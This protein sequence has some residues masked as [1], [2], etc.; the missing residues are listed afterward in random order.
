MIFNVIFPET[1]IIC[2]NGLLN[3]QKLRQVYLTM[4]TISPRFVCKHNTMYMK[5]FLSLF[6]A[7]AIVSSVW[8]GGDLTS[9]QKVLS[10]SKEDLQ[11]HWKKNHLPEYLVPVSNGVDVLEVEYTSSMPDG[12]PVT[13][14]GLL[15]IPRG[16]TKGKTAMMVYHHGTDL[17]RE[18]KVD[19]K[20]EQTICLVF[21]ADGYV[22]LMPDYFGLGKSSAPLHPYQ[23]AETE[24]QSSID[25]IRA[26]RKG[27]KELDI[28]TEER[29]FITG[30]S[31]GGHAAMSTH[32]FI[33]E[34]HKDEF[35]VWAS[36]PMSGA[37]DMTGAQR[38]VMYVPYTN[39]G[40]LP[41]ILFSYNTLYH[42]YKNP[43]EVLKAP[44]DTILPPMF[45]GVYSMGDVN[46]KMPPIPKDVFKDEALH[47][48]ETNPNFPFR[49]ALE[50]NNVYD[51]KAEEPV[52]LC[53]CKADEQV[54][55]KNSLVAH[56][57]MKAKGSKHVMLRPSGRKFDHGQCAVYTSVYTK[58]W[59]DSFRKGSKKGRR[60]DPWKRFIL[61]IG[62]KKLSKAG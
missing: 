20:G 13:A 21:A 40:Y 53:Y 16:Y 8:A 23:H 4:W 5:R 15:F 26:V 1:P 36:S 61:E 62:K 31:Q 19:L 50:E 54:Y 44:Y 47:A 33:T 7:F 51:W 48:F 32:K 52:M 37:Y 18:R 27:K 39:P 22:V 49:K 59:F 35:K 46:K 11:A 45:N 30:Y 24:A 42:F 58:Y 60:G 29:I 43:S 25:M 34:R 17:V 9:Y 14:S 28:D 6:A 57:A 41:Y 12:S 2:L 10:L 55:Y 56:K 38:D 3:S